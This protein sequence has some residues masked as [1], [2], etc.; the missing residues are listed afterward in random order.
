MIEKIKYLM[1]TFILTMFYKR[2]TDPNL[3]ERIVN[4]CAKNKVS[5]SKF[6]YS[7]KR[8]F[9]WDVEI[10]LQAVDGKRGILIVHK[11]FF[12]KKEIDELNMNIA[13]Y[14]YE[15]K[16]VSGGW[17]RLLPL[18]WVLLFVLIIFSPLIFGDNYIFYSIATASYFLL[19]VILFLPRIESILLS[20][21][22]LQSQK[23][24][25]AKEK[26]DV[27]VFDMIEPY[28]TIFVWLNFSADSNF[29]SL[30]K[31]NG[32]KIQIW[33]NALIYPLLIS[34]LLAGFSKLIGVP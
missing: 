25:E 6:F 1:W 23:E 12:A 8:R 2:L 28:K 19:L 16:V 5:C 10:V 27:I 32:L 11:D 34:V 18:L 21:H 20:N 22:I 3:L 13:R 4:A 7:E 29:N 15:H 26:R 14:C 30:K 17:G 33:K 31:V 24:L 9:F